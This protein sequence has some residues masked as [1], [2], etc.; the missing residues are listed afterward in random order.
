MKNI[1]KSKFKFSFDLQGNRLAV[2]QNA[3]V[4]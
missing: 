2:G 4:E 3:S 1:N